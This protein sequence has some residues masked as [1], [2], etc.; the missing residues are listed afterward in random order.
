MFDRLQG[1]LTR[2]IPF[3]A[4][5]VTSVRYNSMVP[6]IGYNEKDLPYIIIKDGN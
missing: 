1:L 4:E 3:I 2:E 6:I 5:S